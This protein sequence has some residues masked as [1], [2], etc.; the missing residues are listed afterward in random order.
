MDTFLIRTRTVAKMLMS[1]WLIMAVVVKM[2]FV[3]MRSGG[4][5]VSLCVGRVLGR[6][7]MEIRII[8]WG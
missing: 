8:F 3:L 6:G 4:L 1:V 7:R 2:S 5:C